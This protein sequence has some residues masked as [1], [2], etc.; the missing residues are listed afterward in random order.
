MLGNFALLHAT[1]GQ[2]AGASFTQRL[3]KAH[4]Q[5]NFSQFPDYRGV[6]D[7]TNPSARTLWQHGGRE[8][9]ALES[10]FLIGGPPKI[11]VRKGHESIPLREKPG[12][13]TQFVE[14]NLKTYP[15]WTSMHAPS[16]CSHFLDPLASK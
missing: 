6:W 1:G 11:L 15:A 14:P 5:I 9:A 8:A 4:Q 2:S 10:P 7:K 16:S 12:P 3:D 13:D